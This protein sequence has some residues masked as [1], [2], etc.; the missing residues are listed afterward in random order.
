MANITGLWLLR[1]SGDALKVADLTVL[2]LLCA[3]VIILLS[4]IG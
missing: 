2:I 1:T 4:G 3:V